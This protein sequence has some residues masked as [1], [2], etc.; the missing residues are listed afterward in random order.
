MSCSALCGR[1]DGS[2]S[3]LARGV[4]ADLR[5]LVVSIAARAMAVVAT[6][7][8]VAAPSRASAQDLADF[9]YENLSFR[10]LGL[11]WGYIWPTSVEPTQTVGLRMD[12][13]YLGPNVRVL[14]GITYW[15]SRMKRSEVQDLEMRVEEL[16]DRQAAPGTPPALIDL[17]TIERSDLAL[18]VDAQI[19]WRAPAG[20]LGFAGLGAGAHML[21]GGGDAV[22]DT[23]VE[24][25]LDTVTAG[26]NLHAGLEVPVSSGFRLFGMSRIELIENLQ[27]VEIRFGGQFLLGGPAPNELRR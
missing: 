8:M 12:L 7:V 24:D 27:Y 6:V 16:V 10:G 21:N 9:D 20:F 25:L 11:S 26:A 2:P 13:G 23:F 17:G 5:K 1:A 3:V 15:S 14:P 18:S 4:T 19:V 22:A